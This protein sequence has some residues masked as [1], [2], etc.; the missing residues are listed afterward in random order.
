MYRGLVRAGEIAPYP[1]SRLERV[2]RAETRLAARVRRAFGQGA[3]TR[4]L[5]RAFGEILTSDVA[6]TVR[7]VAVAAFD[8][9]ARSINLEAVAST[10]RLVVDP[11]PALVTVVLARL[12][13]RAVPSVPTDPRAALEPTLGG[14]LAALCVE[15]ARR[16]GTLLEF[17]ATLNAPAAAEGVRLDV[18]VRLDGKPYAATLWLFAGSAPT[19]GIPE[20][21]L[22]L[23]GELP[24]AVPLVGAISEGSRADVLTLRQGDVWLPG[25]GWLYLKGDDA[26]RKP[27]PS[28]ILGRAC[29][30]SPTMERGVETGRSEDGRIVVRANLVA[31]EAEP[32]FPRGASGERTKAM[33]EPDETLREI[34]LEAPL[35]VRVEVAS[36]TLTGR[37]WASLGPGDVIETGVPLAE[38]VILRVAGR[39]IAR[40]E[41]VTV[42]GELG[43]RIREITDPGRQA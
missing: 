22:A 29:L 41:L 38:P 10:A 16:T 21:D 1:W 12:L 33:S 13:G 9:A 37:E 7:K 43:V 4:A 8:G 32:R 25:S 11:E 17:R 14:A 30:A 27:G 28:A 18:T 6:I 34:A 39:E 19:S 23:L 15:G 42:D 5:G 3:T 20:P 2:Q 24:I 36:I 31:L 26:D 35:V 40:G